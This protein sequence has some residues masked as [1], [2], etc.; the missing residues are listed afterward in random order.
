M[1]NELNNDELETEVDNT[2]NSDLTN[3]T[4]DKA[5]EVN[6]T[7]ETPKTQTLEFWKEASRKHELNNKTNL[8]KLREAQ[9]TLTKALE[10]RETLT[11]QL[12]DLQ[13]QTKQQVRTNIQLKYGLSDLVTSRLVGETAEELEADAQVWLEETKSKKE[14]E[15][16][17][18]KKP[19]LFQ[20]N[21]VNKLESDG[22]KSI[23]SKHF[24]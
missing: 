13:S 18:T 11:K 15:K 7:D 24:N 1:E 4:Q 5:D 21:I 23:F 10:E 12:E 17:E 6:K 8:K 20:G 22:G 3:E 19:N 16:Q 2:D 9:D 14:E